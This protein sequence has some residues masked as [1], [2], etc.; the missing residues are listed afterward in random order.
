[1]VLKVVTAKRVAVCMIAPI[2]SK[3]GLSEQK[4]DSLNTY[5]SQMQCNHSKSITHTFFTLLP[6]KGGVAGEVALNYYF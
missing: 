5:V 3:T 2:V 1:M 4:Q 6:T